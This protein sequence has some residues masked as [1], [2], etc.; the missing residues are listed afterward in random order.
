MVSQMSEEHKLSNEQV[1][2]EMA[3]VRQDIQDVKYIL[4]QFR[5]AAG[6]RSRRGLFSRR[7]SIPVTVEPEVPNK[8]QMLRLDELL[9][10]LPQLGGMIPQLKN[11]K[12]AET[13]RVLSNPAVAGMIQQFVASNKA[14]PAAL[15]KGRSR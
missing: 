5:L 14:K 7:R 13:I 15:P 4:N 10:L 8:Q 9:P 3:S 12:V 11:P 6:K 1:L 2:Q